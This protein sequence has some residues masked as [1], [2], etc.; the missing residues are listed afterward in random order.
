MALSAWVLPVLTAQGYTLV[1]GPPR[2]EPDTGMLML[3]HP[4]HSIAIAYMFDA[5]RDVMQFAA[6]MD[7]TYIDV[8]R[9]VNR[10]GTSDWLTWYLYARR[11][12]FQS[13]RF[14]TAGGKDLVLRLALERMFDHSPPLY[15]GIE[16]IDQ[17]T[18]GRAPMARPAVPT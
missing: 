6:G 10:A 5:E 18:E 13:L 8:A 4:V 7:G 3:V 17:E 16:V 9:G 12:E 11:I 14:R 2:P 15:L 1:A